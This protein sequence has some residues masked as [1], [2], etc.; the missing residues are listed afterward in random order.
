MASKGHAKHRQNIC[1]NQLQGLLTA[2]YL[3]PLTAND[4]IAQLVE[5]YTFNV[6]VL[7]SSPSRVTK[8]SNW[9]SV[10]FFDCI[11]FCPGAETGRQAWLRAMCSLGRGGSIPPLGTTKAASYEAAFSVLS[12]HTN[13]A[14][15]VPR[16]CA[17]CYHL[18]A[19]ALA[20]RFL[21]EAL[22]TRLR[23]PYPSL[24][25]ALTGYASYTPSRAHP[26]HESYPL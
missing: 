14:I 23:C 19:L 13:E 8:K 2:V 22:A 17:Q 21:Q 4:S 20:G 16:V 1:K 7:G 9:P 5:Q 6:W 10:A 25:A 12:D 11:E 3:H 24:P 15:P 26:A 18:F